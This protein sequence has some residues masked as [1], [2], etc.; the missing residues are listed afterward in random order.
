MADFNISRFKENFRA[1]GARPNLF[2][3]EV[4]GVDSKISFTARAASL[5][6]MTLGTIEVPY[7][8]RKVKVAGDR[9]FAE[10][11]VTIMNDEDF[12]IRRQLELWN[13][14]INLHDANVRVNPYNITGGLG[15]SYK[16]DAHVKHF[17]KSGNIIAEYRFIGLYPSEV[18]AIELA[19]DTND[20][21]EE[22]TVTF[23]Y[24][25]FN[26]LFTNDPNAPIV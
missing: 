14:N 25:F 1:G 7:E 19:W 16:R 10:W 20:T 22:F 26:N 21:I 18:G 17:D 3:I 11:T 12:K 23:Q 8:G 24:D 9:T 4:A 6:A 2:R 5:P 13:N 15:D